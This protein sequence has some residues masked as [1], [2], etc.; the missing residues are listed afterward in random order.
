[1]NIF[2]GK[3]KKKKCL[4]SRYSDGVEITV[5]NVVWFKSFTRTLDGVVFVHSYMKI[6]LCKR[7]KRKKYEICA[8]L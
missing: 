2:S 5:L 4:K 8:E 3:A 7:R 6:F 1:M